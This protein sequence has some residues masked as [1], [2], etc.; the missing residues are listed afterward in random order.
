MKIPS[1]L[2]ARLTAL[3]ERIKAKR[4]R[5]RFRVDSPKTGERWVPIFA[6][7]RPNAG[8]CKV[9]SVENFVHL[10]TPI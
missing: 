2:R 6:E 4:Q 7:L 3:G 1:E 9:I 8:C 5:D 10:I